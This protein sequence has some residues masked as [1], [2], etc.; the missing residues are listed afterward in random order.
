MTLALS[1]IF[2]QLAHSK[3]EITFCVD[4]SLKFRIID[5]P[6]NDTNYFRIIEKGKSVSMH[7]GR[8]FLKAGDNVGEHSTENYEEL[9]VILKGYGEVENH[10]KE[11]YEIKEGQVIYIPPNS[12]HNIYNTGTEPLIYI[13]IVSKAY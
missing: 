6:L 4:D 12:S 3:S 10:L 11:R 2:T 7:S 1:I 5:V 9:I 13:Y 8:V